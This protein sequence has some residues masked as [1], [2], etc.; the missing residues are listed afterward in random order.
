MKTAILF[1]ATGLIG[2]NLL[3]LLIT[4]QEYYKIKI[5]TRR[6]FKKKHPKLEIHNVNFNQ[7][8]LHSKDIAGDDCFFCI[9][10]TRKQTPNKQDYI[11]VE[12][13][14]P[15]KIAK[16]A[17]LNKVNSFIYVSSGGANAKSKNLYLQ[18][19]GKA[20]SEIIKLSF[21]YT[22]I[23]QP[24]LLLGKRNQ[25]RITE[26]IAQF[27]FKNLSFIFIGKLKPFKAIQSKTVAN[28]IIKIITTNKNDIYFS[29]EKLADLGV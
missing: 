4:N 20:E 2:N 24:S 23:I 21:N 13:N 7:I 10:T 1:G 3:D 19:K 17:K 8:D 9:G 18:N 25:T 16:I 28:A 22:A 5:F 29:S 15:I 14:L 27:I 11:N 12:L 6:S 26:S